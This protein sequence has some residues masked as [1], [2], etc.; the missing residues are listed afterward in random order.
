MKLVDFSETG[1]FFLPEA[2]RKYFKQ[3]LDTL[4]KTESE[5]QDLMIQ[6]KEEKSIPK[7]ITVGDVTTQTL[8]ENSIVPDLAII[9]DYVQRKQSSLVDLSQFQVYEVKNPAGII[10]FEAWKM[11]RQAIKID[12]NKIIIKITG[13]EDLLVL[14]VISETPYN[15]KVLY[16]QP[17]EGLVSVTVT[18]KI[19]TKI[20][21]LIQKMVKINE[22]Y[23]HK[24]N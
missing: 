21:S 23:N 18:R 24:Q 12:D 10:T 19:K 16:G 13:E 1:Y 5:V 7:I 8:L 2:E 17:N 22:N 11:I 15:S 4:Y 20:Q 9:D 14:P 3:P 6:L